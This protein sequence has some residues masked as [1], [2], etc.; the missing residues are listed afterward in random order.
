MHW[1]QWGKLSLLL[2]LISIDAVLILLVGV[3]RFRRGFAG[4][5]LGL[6]CQSPE[7]EEE[8]LSR[9]DRLPTF[10]QIAV[11]VHRGLAPR[12]RLFRGE[13]LERSTSEDP[14]L[15]KFAH[16]RTKIRKARRMGHAILIRHV[17]GWGWTAAREGAGEGISLR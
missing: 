15:V 2:S 6:R 12:Y 3:G 5:G 7:K 10:L 13:C 17:G 4:R 8:V 16:E 14:L 11:V 1:C 9:I